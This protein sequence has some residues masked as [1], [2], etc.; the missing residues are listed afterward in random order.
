[1]DYHNAIW[2]SIGCIA[3]MNNTS[4]SGLA[5]MCGLDAT[6]FNYSK[7]ISVYGQPRWISTATLAKVLIKTKITPK[8]FA[9]ILQS[10]LDKQQEK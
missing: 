10:C 4:C 7:R 1:M 8:Q 5:K 3:D 9:E 6:V 2:Q